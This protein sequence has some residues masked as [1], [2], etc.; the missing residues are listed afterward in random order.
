MNTLLNLLLNK[1]VT[2]LAGGGLKIRGRL[3]HYSP[4]NGSGKPHKPFILIVTPG[5]N[6]S[7]YVIV[8]QWTA[9]AT[10]QKEIA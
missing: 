10:E 1:N 6:P 8:R 4:S 9:V 3:I 2:V 7:N 5:S